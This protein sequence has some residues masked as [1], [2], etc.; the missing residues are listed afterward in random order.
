MSGLLAV[1]VISLVVGGGLTARLEPFYNF[2]HFK[3]PNTGSL[4]KRVVRPAHLPGFTESKTAFQLSPSPS[5]YFRPSPQPAYAPVST[6]N[7]QPTISYTSAEPQP[8]SPSYTA[9]PTPSAPPA[10]SRPTAAAAAPA[11]AYRPS[12]PGP[13]PFTFFAKNAIDSMTVKVMASKP[14]TTT[15]TTTVAPSTT[16]T[17]ATT[18]TTT[19]TVA[20]ILTTT[21]KA[22]MSPMKLL[23]MAMKRLHEM[24]EEKAA[25]QNE[26]PDV[27][28]REGDV[29]VADLVPLVP[30]QMGEVVSVD[31]NSHTQTN[32]M[33]IVMFDQ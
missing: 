19:T 1:Q 28:V 15:T 21:K 26:I 6:Y 10:T 32:D 8:P 5:G 2:G 9:A 3:V 30:V 18:T 4:A 31:S 17:E 23:M 29:E 27:E 13:T 12:Y 24:E 33:N 20:P 14:P 7:P 11:A 16:T 25:M 22:E